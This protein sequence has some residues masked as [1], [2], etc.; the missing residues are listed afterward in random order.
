MNKLFNLH[1]DLHSLCNQSSSFFHQ[2]KNHSGIKKFY[3]LVILMIFL[4]S[5]QLHAAGTYFDV[6]NTNH[7]SIAIGTG[8]DA[9][10]YIDFKTMVLETAG[11]DDGMRKCEFYIIEDN[12]TETKILSMDNANLVHDGIPLDAFTPTNSAANGFIASGYPTYTTSGTIIQANFKWYYPQRL[13]SKPINIRMKYIWDIYLDGKGDTE[14]SNDITISLPT[15][16]LSNTLGLI[17][18]PVS[19]NKFRISWNNSPNISK[20]IITYDGTIDSIIVA[21]NSTM[22]DFTAINVKIDRAFTFK[23][24]PVY[25][26]QNPPGDTYTKRYQGESVDVSNVGFKFPN[27]ITAT[28]SASIQNISL[29]WTIGNYYGNN[30]SYYVKRG[31]TIL[32]G[33]VGAGFLDFMPGCSEPLKNWSSYTYTIYTVPL[34]GSIADS[35]SYLTKKITVNTNPNKPQF[36]SFNYIAYP[37]DGN[38]KPYIQLNDYQLLHPKKLITFASKKSDEFT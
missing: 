30:V 14:K 29:T 27:V 11:T 13:I 1:S 38:T 31:S 17:V 32:S 34:N 15:P 18:N 12:G 16:P 25:I 37:T 35:L 20:L 36:Y 9:Y 10:N 7:L 21:A 6:N 24:I 26:P 28:Y 5:P 23:V 8:V 19:N 22:V 4:I 2:V 33:T 3:I